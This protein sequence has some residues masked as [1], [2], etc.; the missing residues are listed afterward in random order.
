M[1]LWLATR[2]LRAANTLPKNEALGLASQ[3]RRSAISVPSNIAEGFGRGSRIDYLRF[4]KIARGSLFELDTQL[5]IAR[6][7]GYITAKGYESLLTDWNEV[8][9]VLAGL[10]RHLKSVRR[11][12]PD[13]NAEPRMPN[14]AEQQG[15]TSRAPRERP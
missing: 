2:A 9:K 1:S 15:R 5:L 14:A 10:I 8:S 7:M 6:E 3:I 13:T 12:T 4:L 11:V